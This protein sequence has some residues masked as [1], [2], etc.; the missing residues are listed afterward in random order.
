MTNYLRQT[1]L[2]FLNNSPEVHGLRPSDVVTYYGLH[3]SSQRAAKHRLKRV[4]NN[5]IVGKSETTI[6]PHHIAQEFWN[7][8]CKNMRSKYRLTVWV[9]FDG[10]TNFRMDRISS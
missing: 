2:N 1:A 8:I 5:L 6:I 3:P 4:M 10:G 7:T 9:A